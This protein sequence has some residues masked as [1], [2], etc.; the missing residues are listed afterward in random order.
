MLDGTYFS[1]YPHPKYHMCGNGNEFLGEKSMQIIKL[2]HLM[3][4]P[5]AVKNLQANLVECVHQ[6]LNSMSCLHNIENRIL[7]PREPLTDILRVFVQAVQLAACMTL[8]AS[9]VQVVFRRDVLFDL[10]FKGK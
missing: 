3:E 5:A 1:H 4:I 10:L 9:L 2:H 6:T 8:K 7:D